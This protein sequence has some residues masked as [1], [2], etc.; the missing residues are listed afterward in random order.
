MLSK[1]LT[2]PDKFS[3][4]D[5]LTYEGQ[6]TL[7]LTGS[8][9]RLLKKALLSINSLS[10]DAPLVAI[11]WLWFFSHIY[12]C[13]IIPA[14]YYILF[15]VTWLAYSGDRLL[16]TLR[17]P[18]SIRNT[19][20]HRFTSQHFVPLLGLWLLT[21]TFSVCFLLMA[22]NSTELKWG[23]CLLSLLAL[24]F[25]SC[26]CFPHLA[27]SFLP[28]EF[29]VGMFFSIAT[30]FFIVVQQP[31]WAPYQFWT[32]FSFFA[33]CTL[34]C[35]AISRWEFTSDLDAREVT[36]FTSNPERLKQFH[37]I[38]IVFLILQ[39]VISILM[40]WNQQVPVFELSLLLSTL[41]LIGLDRGNVSSRLK[42][43]L[44]DLALLTPWLI[45]SILS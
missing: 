8:I 2:S 30:H 12:N 18:G 40:M 19:P 35:L 22:L 41:L 28:R 33:I 3:H 9:R 6:N 27:R 24:Y 25:V 42:P 11:T 44:A 15:S 31:A 21:A 39:S 36:F 34:N 10:L 23:F 29:L 5:K 32:G 38:L 16:D 26:F 13:Y 17:T 43:V 1:I 37:H 45:L 14:H 20:R 4:P 7:S